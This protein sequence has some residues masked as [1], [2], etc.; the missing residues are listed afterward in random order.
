M[1]ANGVILYKEVPKWVYMFNLIHSYLTLA[2][3][4]IFIIFKI[5]EFL[6]NKKH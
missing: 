6:I 1:D 5:R 3:M 4:P 2:M